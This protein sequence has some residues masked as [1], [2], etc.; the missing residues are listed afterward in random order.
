MIALLV[1]SL[2]LLPSGV[3]PSQSSDG[4]SNESNDQRTPGNATCSLLR[5][6]DR[7]QVG[8]PEA[9]PVIEL[10]QSEDSKLLRGWAFAR[11]GAPADLVFDV[12]TDHNRFSAF[13]PYVLASEERDQDAATRQGDNSVVLFQRLDLPFPLSNREYEIE[14]RRTETVVDGARCRQEAWTYVPHSGNVDANEGRWEVLPVDE[15]NSLVAYAAFVDP[16]GHV[17]PWMSN[18]ATKRALPKV[19]AAVRHEATRRL[20]AQAGR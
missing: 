18:W 10:R 1:S 13:M 2:L 5:A 16:G 8:G 17:A 7:S 3:T 6:F 14:L 4:T 12:V 11:I 15:N 20:A 19:I 9:A